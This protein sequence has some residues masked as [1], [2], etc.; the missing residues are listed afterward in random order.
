MSVRA[1]GNGHWGRVGESASRHKDATVAKARE[2]R[3]Q[4]RMLRE[5]AE[6][7]GV[8]MGTVQAWVYGY[9]RRQNIVT[10]TVMVTRRIPI[11]VPNEQFG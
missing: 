4:G 6:E 9:R 7:L 11:E 5:I 8:P 1:H 3:K 10:R 2:L